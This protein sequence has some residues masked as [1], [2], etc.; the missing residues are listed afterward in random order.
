INIG[1]GAEYERHVVTF[2]GVGEV[3]GG[4][5]WNR[6]RLRPPLEF[7]R[8]AGCCPSGCRICL[9][10][11]IWTGD[12]LGELMM[13]GV[14]VVGFSLFIS[15]YAS[16]SG[17]RNPVWTRP[18]LPGGNTVGHG[19]GCC[20]TGSL[21]HIRSFMAVRSACDGGG[22]W[23]SAGMRVDSGRLVELLGEEE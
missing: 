1:C 9:G 5:S 10:M 23:R 15:S 16:W 2:S 4:C 7:T 20:G 8:L 17:C 19:S 21:P 18:V 13:A 11:Q 6:P 22:D 12:P 3:R 14:G